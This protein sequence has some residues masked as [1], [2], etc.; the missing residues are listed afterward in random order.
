MQPKQSAPVLS[1]VSK[2]SEQELAQIVEERLQ[3]RLREM[4]N[5]QSA[6]GTTADKPKDDLMGPPSR[7]KHSGPW[8]AKTVKQK[9][10]HGPLTRAEREQLAAD[11]RLTWESDDAELDLLEDKLSPPED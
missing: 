9:G 6:R 11:L 3:E 5:T 10:S 7:R 8:V 1:S 4:T 2:V